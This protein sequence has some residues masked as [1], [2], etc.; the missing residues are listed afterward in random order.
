[1]SGFRPI[2]DVSGSSYTGKIQQYAVAASHSTLLATG[3]LVRETGVANG[4][5]VAQVDAVAAGQ[6][7]TGVIVGFLPDFSNLEQKG[8]PANQAGTALVAVNPDLLLMARTSGAEIELADV[9]QNADVSATA[10]TM[11][12]GLVTSNMTVN[13]ST[14]GS[15]TAQVRIV[16]IVDPTN[17]AVGTDIIVRINEST[18]RTTAG[19]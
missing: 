6:A 15:G 8:L 13:M 10:A 17:L 4:E 5:G 1:M 14:H 18:F 2:Q 9:G 12:G 7:I 19:V 11:E 3:D 16:R